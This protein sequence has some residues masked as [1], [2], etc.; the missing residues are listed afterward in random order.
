MNHKHIIGIDVAS[1]VSTAAVLNSSGRLVFE[2][3]VL[4][5]A[6]TL[7]QLV[8]SVSRP[9]MVV[10]EECCESAWLYSLLEP[11]CEEILICNSSVI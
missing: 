1:E 10:F 2:S 5:Q 4:T 6:A 7:K 9:R 11:L 8:K 3:P